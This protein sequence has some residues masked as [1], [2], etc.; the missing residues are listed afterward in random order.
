MRRT[1]RFCT[2]LGVVALAAA[3]ARDT[4]DDVV[5]VEPVSTPIFAKDGT[6]IGESRVGDFD[7]DNDNVND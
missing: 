6:V 1:I 4:N 3:C 5:V 2:A 7:T